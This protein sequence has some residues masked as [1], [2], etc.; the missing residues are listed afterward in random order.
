MD[1]D[2][3]PDEKHMIMM[4]KLMYM[5]GRRV[6]RFM[7]N[8]NV[9]DPENH[10]PFPEQTQTLPLQD[11]YDEHDYRENNEGKILI[12]MEK[13]MHML[14]KRMDRLMANMKMDDLERAMLSLDQTQAQS[15]QDQDSD[16]AMNYDQHLIE[17]DEQTYKESNKEGCQEIFDCLPISCTMPIGDLHNQILNTNSEQFFEEMTENPQSFPAS[18]SQD[19]LEEAQ[20]NI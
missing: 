3:D 8:L 16:Q 10:M 14:G 18:T 12:M 4:E 20:E 19:P 6:D 11:M 2:I 15:P 9:G 17:N 5:L 1:L 7:A 13:M